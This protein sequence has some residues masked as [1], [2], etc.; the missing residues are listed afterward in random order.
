MPDIL[1]VDMDSF[2]ASV[3]IRERP[4]LKDKPVAVSGDAVQRS[5]VSTANYAAREYGV[6]SAMPV[7]TALK[8]CPGLIVI[9]ADM[10]KYERISCEV[11][12]LLREFTPEIEPASIDE[13]YLDVSSSHLLFGS[14]I[15]IAEK[16]KKRIRTSFSLTCSIGLSYN[17]LLAKIA[18]NLNKPDGLTVIDEKNMHSLLDPMK[19]GTI[20]GIGPKTSAL[21]NRHGLYTIRDVQGTELSVLKRLLGINALYIY[22]ACRGI[23]SSELIL[24]SDARQISREITLEHDTLD[25]AV[26]RPVLL[27]LSDRVAERL[28]EGGLHGKTIRLKI[29][30]FDFKMTTR[31]VTLLR[32]IN[33][34]NEI[35]QHILE[36]L[37]DLL[38]RPVRL[39]GVG[40]GS[41]SDS[42]EEQQ[43]IFPEEEKKVRLGREKNRDEI[44]RK[45]GKDSIKRASLL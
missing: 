2:F 20:P 19:I 15:E 25:L 38:V 31:Q 41:L 26:L 12:G 44:N 4:E 37:R 9:K 22:N 7:M 16:I 40:V 39:A 8:K 33:T 43:L 35:F 18:S 42:G 5:V 27:E 11:S 45:F 29:R 36:M 10:E 21:L 3:E 34:A 30:Y 1:H 24:E 13:F 28:R 6:F 32:P 17:K 23:G 14:S